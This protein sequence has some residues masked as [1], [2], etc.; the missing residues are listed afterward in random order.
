[1]HQ[2]PDGAAPRPSHAV[3]PAARGAAAAG[4]PTAARGPAA[5]GAAP[6]L[7]DD[8]DDLHAHDDFRR[9]RASGD[10]AL[11]DALV[12]R[13]RGLA[14]AMARRYADRGVDHDDLCQVAMIGLVNAV[15]RFDPDQGAAFSTYAVPTILGELKHHFRDH[16][17]TIKVPRRLQNLRRAA[18]RARDTLEQADGLT[19]SVEDVA[20]LID[21]EPEE[22]RAALE[23]ISSCYQPGSL[24]RRH[25]PDIPADDA[26][27]EAVVSR[28]D[29]VRHLLSTLSTRDRRIFVLRYYG[30]MT[31]QEIADVIGISQM[32]VSR[33]LRKGIDQMRDAA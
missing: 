6:A 32:H 27:V 15:E 22:V 30:S 7:A 5:P 13:H 29:Q 23:A 16:A 20:A 1:V 26:S 25:R 2:L 31:Q 12:E 10:P 11:R 4:E 28:D 8:R 21:E 3:A 17:W 19:P 33:L 18:V 14:I 24:E 9:L